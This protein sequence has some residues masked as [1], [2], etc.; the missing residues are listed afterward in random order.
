M[1]A[2]ENFE[3]NFFLKRF[4]Q[5]KEFYLVDFFEGIFSIIIDKKRIG[6]R[7]Q[8]NVNQIL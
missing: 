2:K 8:T 4:I 5:Y 7:D 6:S 1:K 3:R